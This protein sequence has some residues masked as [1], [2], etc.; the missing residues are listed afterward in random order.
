VP[1]PAQHA[2]T[3]RLL[4]DWLQLDMEHLLVRPEANGL[5]PRNLLQNLPLSTLVQVGSTVRNLVLAIVTVSIDT[6]AADV[7]TAED[8]AN[9]IMT[10][11]DIRLP[12]YTTPDGAAWVKE[13]TVVSGPKQLP[14]DSTAIGRLGAI[15][16]ITVRS[17]L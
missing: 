16:Q 8:I 5:P 10:G 17:Q 14:Y 2:S 4:R 6:Y 3:F 15:Y 9:A 12:G 13:T 7:D 11:V 1:A